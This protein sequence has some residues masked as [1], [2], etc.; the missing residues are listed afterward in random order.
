M[1]FS[2]IFYLVNCTSLASIRWSGSSDLLLE[3]IDEPLFVCDQLNRDAGFWL[4][5]RSDMGELPLPWDT[6]E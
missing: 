3:Y 1:S 2:I 5:R 4:G 6:I